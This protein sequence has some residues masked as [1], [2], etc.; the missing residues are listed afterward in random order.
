MKTIILLY[1]SLFIFSCS[2]DNERHTPISNVY[3][4][5]HEGLP[6]P[7]IPDDNLL[8]IQG[9]ELG[10]KLFYENMLSK[11]ESISCA[12]CHV[13]ANAFS[14]INQFSIGVRELPGTRQSMAIFN[15]AWNDNDFFWD[16]RA[17]TLR[18]QVLMPIQDILEMDETLENV[19]SKLQGNLEYVTYFEEVFGTPEI[20]STNISLA[21]EQFVHSI[22][23]NKSKYDKF[24][25]NEA[26][27]TP[28]EERGKN[29]FF[30]KYDPLSPNTA[31]ANCAQCHGGPN[32]ENDD[33]MNNGLDFES[34]I[35]DIGRANVINSASSIGT[36]KVP[37]L[38]N[39]ELTPPYMHDGRFQTLEEVID[40]Y[41]EG[42]KYSST[43]NPTLLSISNLGPLLNE[44]QKSDIVAFLKTLT[45]Y[46]LIS[47]PKY[48]NP[49]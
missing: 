36:F 11:D 3:N 41:S 26:T 24:L 39:I 35:T 37:S 16:G 12:T 22:V 5:E 34:D 9:V 31:F 38:R 21:L 6:N 1:I 30:K 43:V 40:H 4:L 33:Y 27:L 17:H 49:F 7:Y 18:D 44:Q 28:A 10:R 14:D 25:K 42:I 23:S 45:D 29:L 20:N 32:F 19:I 47:N 2:K 15:M 13:Q 8:T 46:E 48:S